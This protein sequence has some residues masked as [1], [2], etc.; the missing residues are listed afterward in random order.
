MVTAGASK[1][2]WESQPRDPETGR[3]LR[4]DEEQ[5]RSEII[6]IRLTPRERRQIEQAAEAAGSTITNF[7]VLSALGER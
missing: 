5:P 1:N 4:R 2:D 6:H 3:F 7:L